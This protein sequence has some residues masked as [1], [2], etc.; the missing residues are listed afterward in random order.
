MDDEEIEILNQ[1]YR[2]CMDTSTTE[3]EAIS[4]IAGIVE[5]RLS[6]QGIV[7]DGYEHGV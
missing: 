7:P 4:I 3:Q 1:I 6:E 5:D 2:T